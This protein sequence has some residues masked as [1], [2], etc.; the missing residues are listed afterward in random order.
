MSTGTRSVFYG[1]GAWVGQQTSL[2]GT[3][4]W[5][6]D[7]S[8]LAVPFD[9]NQLITSDLSKNPHAVRSGQIQFGAVEVDDPPTYG[10][11]TKIGPSWPTGSTWNS[12]WIESTRYTN[13]PVGSR[14]P[15]VGYGM[16]C[17]AYEL[18]SVVYWSGPLINRRFWGFYAEITSEQSANAL[19]SIWPAGK[20]QIPGQAPAGSWWLNLS[21]VA[22]PIE[23]NFTQIG[24]G[25]QAPKQGALFLDAVTVRNLHLPDPKLPPS[26]GADFYP[27]PR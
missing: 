6:R 20:S 8:A 17:R 24:V 1:L 13:I 10:G 5:A 12:C 18:T 3:R 22:H 15:R 21:Q 7:P 19:C 27:P 23:A 14:P 2:T 9:P 11:A 26:C 16:Q 4:W 25:L